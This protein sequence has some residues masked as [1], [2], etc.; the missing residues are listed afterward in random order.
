MQSLIEEY[1][2]FAIA[3]IA[4]AALMVMLSAFQ[5]GFKDLSQEFIRNITGVNSTYDEDIDEE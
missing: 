2:T 5:S 3:A 4:F 1:G